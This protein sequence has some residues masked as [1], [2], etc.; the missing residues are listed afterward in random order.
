MLFLIILSKSLLIL[1]ILLRNHHI[2]IFI[3]SPL[4]INSWGLIRSILI[5]QMLLWIKKIILVTTKSTFRFP[6]DFSQVWFVVLRIYIRCLILW[7]KIFAFVALLFYIICII[8]IYFDSRF[9][10][11]ILCNELLK[12]WVV[13]SWRVL[14]LVVNF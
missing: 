12:I 10:M 9:R 3:N 8:A 4:L 7:I 13:C 5:K 6:T 2:K 11:K 14:A 1:I